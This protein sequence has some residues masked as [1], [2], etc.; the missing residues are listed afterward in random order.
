LTFARAVEKF[1][2]DDSGQSRVATIDR[3]EIPAERLHPKAA[4]PRW[5]P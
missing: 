5:R 4:N 3:Q 2:D 1:S